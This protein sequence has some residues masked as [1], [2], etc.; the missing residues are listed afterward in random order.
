[1]ALLHHNCRDVGIFGELVKV[2]KSLFIDV[3][4]F[5]S[6][7]FTFVARSSNTSDYCF[8]GAVSLICTAPSTAAILLLNLIG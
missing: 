5:R 2:R 4:S 8:V 3:S 7:T 1:M 6:C